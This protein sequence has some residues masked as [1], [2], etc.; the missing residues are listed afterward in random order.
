MKRKRKEEERRRETYIL[1]AIIN[2]SWEKKNNHPSHASEKKM[3]V[4]FILFD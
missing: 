3:D 1:Q 4:Y 2:D